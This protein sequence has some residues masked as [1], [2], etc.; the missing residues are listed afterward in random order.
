[1]RIRL[2]A[3]VEHDLPELRERKVADR[4]AVDQRVRRLVA[5]ADLLEQRGVRRGEH[6]AERLHA[7]IR[8]HAGDGVAAVVDEDVDRVG[9][10][11]QAHGTP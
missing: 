8:A 2:P 5:R 1:V 9:F 7:R 11:G 3:E 10:C 4:L 6:A